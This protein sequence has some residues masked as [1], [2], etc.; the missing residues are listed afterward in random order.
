MNV[1]GIIGS[2]EMALCGIGQTVPDLCFGTLGKDNLKDI[3]IN[4]PRLKE[5]REGL[6]GKFPGICGDCIHSSQCF[7]NCI[8]QNYVENGELISPDSMCIET[9]KRGLFPNSRRQ[10]NTQNSDAETNAV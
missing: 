9:E 2:G 5:I 6:T 3:W 7:M 1:L 4:H 10:L 8:A